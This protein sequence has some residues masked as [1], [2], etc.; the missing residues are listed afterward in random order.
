LFKGDVKNIFRDFKDRFVKISEDFEYG[1]TFATNG[2]YV[3]L[4]FAGKEVK[5]IPVYYQTWLENME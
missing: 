5:R 2:K 3:I 1:E 4:D